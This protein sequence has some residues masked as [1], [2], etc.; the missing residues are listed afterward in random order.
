MVDP[1]GQ[2][3]G[4]DQG[5]LQAPCCVSYEASDSVGNPG[6]TFASTSNAYAFAK[7]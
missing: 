2:G 4:L 1:P 7:Y 3:Q 5:I 6:E